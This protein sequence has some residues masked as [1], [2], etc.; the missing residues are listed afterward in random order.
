MS[1]RNDN[2]MNELLQAYEADKERRNVREDELQAAKDYL[3]VLLQE[4]ESKNRELEEKKAEAG[5]LADALKKSEDEKQAEVKAN[6]E[7][8]ESNRYKS[9][10]IGIA[11]IEFLVVIA[12]IISLF[13]VYDSLKNDNDGKSN[14]PNGTVQQDPDSQNVTATPAPVTGKNIEDLSAVVSQISSKLEDGFDCSIETIDGLEYLVFSSYGF[15]LGYK[16]EYYLN[17]TAHKKAIFFEKGDKRIV[18]PFEYDFE[19]NPE[20]LCPKWCNMNGTKMVVLTD[21]TGYG[22][23][24]DTFRIIDINDLTEYYGDNQKA[25]ETL[26]NKILSLMKNVGFSDLPSGLAELPILFEFETSKAS[27]KYGLTDS[28]YSEIGYNNESGTNNKDLVDISSEFRLEIGEEGISWTTVVKLGR[29]YYLGELKGDLLLGQGSVVVGNVKFGAYVNPNVED[30]DMLGIIVPA[31]SIPERY[32]TI[33]GYNSERYYV[34]IN[35]KI[36]ECTYD[37]SRLD[38]TDSNN[39]TYL[40]ENGAKA[41]IRGIDVSKYQGVIDW[42]KV[43]AA[44]VEFAIIRMGYRGMNEGTLEVDP[45]FEANMKGASEAGIKTGVYFF[46]QAITKEEAEEE[47]KFVLDAIDKYNVTYPVIF[48]TERVTTYNARANGLSYEQRTDMCIAF[49]DKVAAAGYTPMIYANTKYMIM[50]INLE[51]LAKYDRWFA[52]YSSNITFPYSFQMFQY[53]ESGSIPGIKGNVDLNI[54]FVDYSKADDSNE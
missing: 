43:A 28:G 49:C 6:E 54:S 20:T 3:G 47:A 26:S 44:G 29:K 45:Y 51:R 34:A 1:E 10:W 30:P 50:G 22:R 9:I 18:E 12:L 40:D 52:A 32:I 41:S 35:D 13:V 21:Y 5:K 38:T 19:I 46:S 48:D 8:K 2:D 31:E 27:Y 24:P 14:D 4:I 33:N 11:I 17:D 39:W 7:A 16:N 15:K 42:K 25:K 36:P 53:S 37:W 23:I